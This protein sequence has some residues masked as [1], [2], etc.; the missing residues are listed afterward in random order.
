MASLAFVVG[1]LFLAVLTVGPLCFIL[2]KIRIVPD[3]LI[4]MLGILSIAIGIWWLLLPISIAR[5]VGLVPCI[6]GFISIKNRR[7]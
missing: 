7:I 6:L 2:S 4:W 3:I 5:Y 1:L